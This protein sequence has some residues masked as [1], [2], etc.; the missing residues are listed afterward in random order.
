LPIFAAFF[1]LCAVLIFML[2]VTLQVDREGIRGMTAFRGERNIAWR[3]VAAVKWSPFNKWLVIVDRQGSKLCV[4]I[5]M[6]G[7]QAAVMALRQHVPEPVWSKAVAAWE[8]APKN[9]F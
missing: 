6:Q 4:S 8:K 3:D 5:L 9:M 2:R 7:H 1:V